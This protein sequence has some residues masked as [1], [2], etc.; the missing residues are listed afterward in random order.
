MLIDQVDTFGIGTEGFI[1]L[2]TSFVVTIHRRASLRPPEDCTLLT[3]VLN[4]IQGQ[5]SVP[6]PRWASSVLHA[7]S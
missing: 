2:I 7:T 3:V 1:G 5:Q 4:A 6:V